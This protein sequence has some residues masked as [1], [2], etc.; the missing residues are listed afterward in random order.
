MAAPAGLDRLTAN[1]SV[2]SDTASPMV[3]TRIV[4]LASPGAKVSVP[5]V[6]A[7]AAPQ[8]ALGRGSRCNRHSPG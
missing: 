4:L 3:C 7:V 8:A 1:V 6:G 2:G 5:M